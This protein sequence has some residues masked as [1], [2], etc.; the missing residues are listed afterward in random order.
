MSEFASDVA[1]IFRSGVAY[2][3]IDATHIGPLQFQK[4]SVDYFPTHK[5]AKILPAAV[6]I[7]VIPSTC[8]ENENGLLEMI[9]SEELIKYH[10]Q[11]VKV[12]KLL[13]FEVLLTRD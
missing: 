8:N 13:F 5:D 2:K 1:D 7:A 12:K 4:L 10:V 3:K 9:S 6:N 11:I